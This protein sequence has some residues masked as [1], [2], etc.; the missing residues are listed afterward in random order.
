MECYWRS[1]FTI[2]TIYFRVFCLDF[3][4]HGRREWYFVLQIIV[5]SCNSLFLSLPNNAPFQGNIF[6]NF[7]LSKVVVLDQTQQTQTFEWNVCSSNGNVYYIM[8]N[9]FTS[10]YLFITTTLPIIN[11]ISQSTQHS[12]ILSFNIQLCSNCYISFPIGEW[13]CKWIA[14]LCTCLHS[15]IQQNWCVWSVDCDVHRYLHLFIG[16]EIEM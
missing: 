10:N 14:P 9:G 1:C 6:E 7:L 13:K 16:V 5:S 15:T 2:Q 4:L 12:T 3:A 8:S 11:N